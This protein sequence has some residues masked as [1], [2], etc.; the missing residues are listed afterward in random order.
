MAGFGT[1]YKSGRIYMR[2]PKSIFPEKE[3]IQSLVKACVEELYSLSLSS[4]V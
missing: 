2:G 1:Y 3:N 4:E